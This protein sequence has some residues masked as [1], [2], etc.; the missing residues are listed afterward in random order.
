MWKLFEIRLNNE[1][2][3]FSGHQDWAFPSFSTF[4]LLR[5]IFECV[6][7]ECGNT[8]CQFIYFSPFYISHSFLQCSVSVTSTTNLIWNEFHWNYFDIFTSFSFSHGEFPKW[9]GKSKCTSVYIYWTNVKL[10]NKLTCI[11]L[12]TFCIAFNHKRLFF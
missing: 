12:L 9:K 1:N 7:N 6:F 4:H 11:R 8:K 2:V 5:W 10:K 3:T